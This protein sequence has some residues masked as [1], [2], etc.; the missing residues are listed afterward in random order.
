MMVGLDVYVSPSPSSVAQHAPGQ[1]RAIGAAAFVGVSAV[2][3]RLPVLGPVLGFA[4]SALRP[5]PLLGLAAAVAAPWL[6]AAIPLV[7]VDA[8]LILR[9]VRRDGGAK[10]L[11]AVVGAML[12]P[13]EQGAA[14]CA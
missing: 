2:A 6:W 11:R 12:A 13:E 10:P 8:F 5:V 9:R 14:S 3:S 1:L 7:G 4:K